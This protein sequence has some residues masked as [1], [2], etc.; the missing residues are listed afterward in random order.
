MVIIFIA[1][2]IAVFVA[3]MI[4]IMVPAIIAVTVGVLIV[5]T[6]TVAFIGECRHLNHGHTERQ[7][8]QKTQNSYMHCYIPS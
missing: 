2:F 5:T 4:A 3:V 1:V 8:E 6:F 7:R